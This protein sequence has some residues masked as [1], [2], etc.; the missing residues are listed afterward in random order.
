M[1][2]IL[3]GAMLNLLSHGLGLIAAILTEAANSGYSET[4]EFLIGE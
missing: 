3:E 1:A 2:K 4:V